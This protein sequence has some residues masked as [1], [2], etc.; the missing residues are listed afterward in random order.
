VSDPAAA[1]RFWGRWWGK[2]RAFYA[3]CAERVRDLGWEEVRALTGPRVE[4]EAKMA[5]SAVLGLERRALPPVLRVGALQI[6]SLDAQ[7]VAL[8]TYSAHA[9]VALSRAVFDLLGRFDGTPTPEVLAA[10][11]GAEPSFDEELVHQFV[12]HRILVGDTA[13]GA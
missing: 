12:D 11:A 9:P 7:E 13:A 1:R 8:W 5:R 3:A 6:V 2:E 4:L 10:V